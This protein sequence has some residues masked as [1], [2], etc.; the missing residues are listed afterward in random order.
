MFVSWVWYYRWSAVFLAVSISRNLM[1]SML[2]KNCKLCAGNGFWHGVDAH[3]E[4]L[5]L[6][7][8]AQVRDHDH[9]AVFFDTA[10][11]QVV[12]VTVEVPVPGQIQ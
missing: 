11:P 9:L 7:F 1:V 10:L 8:V 2:W 6:N 5:K 3:P 4:S 12:P